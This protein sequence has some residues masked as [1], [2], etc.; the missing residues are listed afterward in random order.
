MTTRGKKR[1]TLTLHLIEKA[2]KS[3]VATGRKRKGMD[4]FNTLAHDGNKAVEKASDYDHQPGVRTRTEK[5]A[6]LIFSVA[7]IRRLMRQ[8][9]ESMRIGL[10]PAIYLTAVIEV[11]VEQMIVYSCQLGESNRITSLRLSV[12]VQND[13]DLHHIFPNAMLSKP[14]KTTKRPKPKPKSKK[15]VQAE[16]TSPEGG[17]MYA[18]GGKRLQL[19]GGQWVHVPEKRLQGGKW[20]PPAER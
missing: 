3:T 6:G 17:Y 10:K 8:S 5:K 7:R 14:T 20:V 16:E 13:G 4:A 15:P 11:L 18:R 12:A 1:K 19:Q 9:S 2:I